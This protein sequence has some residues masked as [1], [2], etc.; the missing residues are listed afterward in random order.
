M[1]LAQGFTVEEMIQLFRGKYGSPEE[2]GWSPRRRLRFGYFQPSDYYEALVARLVSEQTHWLDVGGG[3]AVFPDNPE[4]AHRLATRCARLVAVDPSSNVHDN[5]FAHERVQSLLE[6]FST[7]ER[8]DLAT[9]RMVAEHVDDPSAVASRLAELLK[10]GG[11]VVVFTI[12]K[13]SPVPILTRIVPFRFHYPIKKAFWGGE[14]QDTFPV[15]YR[16]NT[17]RELHATFAGAGFTQVEFS[18]LDDLSTLSGFK[19]LNYLELYGWKA[20]KQLGLR[21]PE[22]DLLAVFARN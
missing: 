4:L 12:N 6:D 15:A 16:M 7:D 8:F 14:E 1:H 3:R 21:Y 18:Y 9:L 11:L 5:P 10:P 19:T 13:W 20:L 22:N 17:R 2:A